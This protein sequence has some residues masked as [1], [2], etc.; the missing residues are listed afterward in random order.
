MVSFPWTKRECLTLHFEP[1]E[2]RV[3]LASNG[4]PE[5]WGLQPIP[6]GVVQNHQVVQPE[7]LAETI[8]QV[9]KSLGIRARKARVALSHPRAIMRVLHIPPVPAKLLPETVYRA[10]RR[11]FPLPL[12]ELYFGWQPLNGHANESATVFTNGVL[13]TSVD[14]YLQA[15]KNAGIQVVA[16][17]LKSL[18]LIR[19]VNHSDVVIVDLEPRLGRVLLVRRYVPYL[20]RTLAQPTLELLESAQ[21]GNYLVGELQQILQFFQSTTA[22]E[23]EPWTPQICLVGRLSNDPELRTLVGAHWP[24]LAPQPPLSYAEELPVDTY[25]PNLGLILKRE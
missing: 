20:V 18:A 13:K 3:L 25:L 16:M 5:L 10:A 9:L 1:D 2:L 14:S 8:S 15:L 7:Q 23:H 11:E 22:E 19:A 24:L 17:E 6:A 21:Q 4:C 12:E